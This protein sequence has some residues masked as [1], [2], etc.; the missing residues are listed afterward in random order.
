VDSTTTFALT[1]T[2]SVTYLFTTE[3][4]DYQ[5]LYY[6]VSGTNGYSVNRIAY[7]GVK[8]NYTDSLTN[9]LPTDKQTTAYNAVQVLAVDASSDWYLPE[10]IEGQ[11]VF[12]SE[13]EEMNTYNYIQVC[14]L[15]A[16]TTSSTTMTNAQLKAQND[17]YN[18]VLA[19]I[20]DVDSDVYENLQDALSYYFWAS[21]IDSDAE[22]Y[23]DSLIKAY[24]DI[25]GKKETY[26]YSVESATMYHDFAQR[27]NDFATVKVDD[28][29]VDFTQ[30]KQING[31]TVY[32]NSSAYYY[33]VLGTMTDDDVDSWLADVKATYTSEYPEDTSTWWDNLSTVAKVFFI[34]GMCVAGLL[35][36]AA[37]VVGA[38]FLW[39][40]K[41][42]GKNG[43][44]RRKRYKVD[45]T[46]DKNIN[47]YEDETKAEQTE[48]KTQE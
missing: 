16:E 29:K 6:A 24:V 2:S 15:R 19:L 37:I 41:K 14:D 26:L 11:L 5:Y 25:E 38:I 1:D 34:I 18:G 22:N 42:S 31:E 27:K 3:E 40:R 48:E 43:T 46:D 30:S 13:I 17:L 44:S 35:V 45:T 21:A 39:K 12:A 20:S 33:S 23:I 32:A 10:L 8:N 36:V 28:T 9:P 7:N 47:V 4:G